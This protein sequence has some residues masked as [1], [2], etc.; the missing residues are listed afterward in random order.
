MPPLHEFHTLADRTYVVFASASNSRKVKEEDE[1]DE[2]ALDK[3][4][5]QLLEPP[6]PA[7]STLSTL[8]SLADDS[9]LGPADSDSEEEDE[10]SGLLVED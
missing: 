4:I 10:V 5:S 3:D 2:E 1:E 9:I 6:S 8:S 7:P